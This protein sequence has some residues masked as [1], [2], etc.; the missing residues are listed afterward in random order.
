MVNDWFER[1]KDDDDLRGGGRLFQGV[2][3]DVKK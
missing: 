3:V 2:Y 1:K